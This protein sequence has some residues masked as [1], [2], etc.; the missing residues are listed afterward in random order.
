LKNLFAILAVL[1]L[2]AVAGRS[3]DVVRAQAQSSKTIMLPPDNALSALKPGAGLE[4]AQSN[5]AICHSTDYIVRQPGG[6]ARHWEPEVRKMI[7]V[8]GAHVTEADV[9]TIV[10]Y[11]AMAYGTPP[12]DLEGAAPGRSQP[13]LPERSDHKQARRVPANSHP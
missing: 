5:C 8:Y 6:D 2:L 13:S 3:A 10:H 4:V 11:L 7:T 9:Q 12:S 1:A